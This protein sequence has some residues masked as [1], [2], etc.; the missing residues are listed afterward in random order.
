MAADDDDDDD[1]D[2]H[3]YDDNHGKFPSTFPKEQQSANA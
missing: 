1:D 2:N 3:N